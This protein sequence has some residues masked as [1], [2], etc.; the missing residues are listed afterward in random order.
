MSRVSELMVAL[1]ITI[2]AVSAPDN[3]PCLVTTGHTLL[4]RATTLGQK[5]MSWQFFSTNN[6]LTSYNVVPFRIHLFLSIAIIPCLV[7][8]FY[9]VS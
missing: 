6:M 2:A 3:Y 1:T 9:F 5:D 7:Y 8:T 4:F